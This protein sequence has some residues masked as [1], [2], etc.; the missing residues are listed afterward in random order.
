M[1]YQMDVKE[2]TCPLKWWEKHEMMFPTI[3]FFVQQILRIISAQSEIERIFSLAR[4][5]VN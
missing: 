5:L 4:I 3:E 1:C 2:I